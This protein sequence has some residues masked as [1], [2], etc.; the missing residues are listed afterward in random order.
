M[1]IYDCFMYFDEDLL[2]DL[3]F[4]TLNK[5]VKKFVIAEATYTHNGTKK[6]LNF[7]I[8]KFKKFKDKIIYI[9][10][11]K[12]P[13][14]ILKI[15]DS[16]TKE[17]KG[18]KLILN[19]M[20]RD[21]FQRENLSRGIEEALNDDLILISD[22]DEIPDLNKIDLS[23]I[24]NKIIIFEQKMFYYKLNLFYQDYTW[25]GTKAVRKK[26]LITP[27]WLRNVK[28]KNY[29]KWRLDTL[30][31]KK[32]YTNLYFIKNGGWHF[33]C[34]RTAE[35]LE[36]KLLNFAHHYEYEESGLSIKDLKKLIEEKRVMYDH[37][38]DQKGY[39]WSGKSILKNYDIDLL[40]EYI[41]SNQKK[42]SDWLD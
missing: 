31:S 18:E 14:N 8:N 27:Q 29:P 24:N 15:L 40:P 10:V 9:I 26:N 5:F 17:Q 32:K 28:G 19:G 23:K 20:A 39:K 16:E 3:R 25:L 6:K 34:L 35:E 12:Q 33:T 30:F 42:Y 2:L 1:N 41:S 21:Y 22:L 37:N 7:D 38:I 13:D 4:N 11:D 36:K